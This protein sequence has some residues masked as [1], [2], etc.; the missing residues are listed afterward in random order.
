MWKE[1][2][3]DSNGNGDKM[4]RDNG[5]SEDSASEVTT[6]DFVGRFDIEDL[7]NSSNGNNSIH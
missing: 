7:V 1:Y 6:M 5:D 3:G 4:R 2:F